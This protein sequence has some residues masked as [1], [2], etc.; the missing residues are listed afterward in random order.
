MTYHCID[1][2]LSEILAV[3]EHL[4]GVDDSPVLAFHSEGTFGACCAASLSVHVG[5]ALEILLVHIERHI[6]VEMAQ[7]F[8]VCVR[9]GGPGVCLNP[10]DVGFLEPCVV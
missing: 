8:Y 7:E 5:C 4:L 2:V 6:E 10:L 3:G 9:S 1:V